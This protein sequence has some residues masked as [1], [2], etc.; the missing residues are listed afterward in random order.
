M[1]SRTRISLGQYAIGQ[2][3]VTVVE[4]MT[5][6]AIIAIATALALPN[7]K[8]WNSRYQLKEA[9]TA[10]HSNLSMARMG[11]MNRNTTVTVQ[12]TAGVVDPDDGKTKITATFTD[13]NGGT[14]ILPQRMNP[15]ITA[16]GGAATIRFN[17]LGLRVGGGTGVQTITLANRDGVTY[18][19]QVNAAGKSR[20]CATSP[21]P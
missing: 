2:A 12:I 15:I 17:S 9:T 7:Y 13:A 6:V 14:V 11:A 16:F 18:E 20:W 8:T 10:L 4:L 21:C 5:V 1:S 3:G 19:I